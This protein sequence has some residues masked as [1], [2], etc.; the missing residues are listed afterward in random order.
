LLIYNQA[1]Q[2]IYSEIKVNEG[3][4]PNIFENNHL[5]INTV[6]LHKCWTVGF[7]KI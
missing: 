2:P 3:L 6:F 1:R 4:W 7:E 5:I